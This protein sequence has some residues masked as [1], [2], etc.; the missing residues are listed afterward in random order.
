MN[1][2]PLRKFLF[3]DLLYA[4]PGVT[5]FFFLAYVFTDKFVELVKKADSYRQVIIVA[6][7]AF[8]AGYLVSYFQKHP[9]SEGDPKE[10]PIIGTQLASHLKEPEN[11]QNN[12]E[13]TLT[14]P[15]AEKIN[16]RKK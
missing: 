1:H 16:E 8:V 12:G 10:V 3:A 2:M 9:V 14:Q 5:T 13:K 4:I 15:T 6:V 7:V 11:S